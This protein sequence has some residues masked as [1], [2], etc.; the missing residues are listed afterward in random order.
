MFEQDIIGF[1]VQNRIKNLTIYFWVSVC[2]TII[3]IEAF[4]VLNQF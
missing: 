1:T 2:Y 4:F 3:I